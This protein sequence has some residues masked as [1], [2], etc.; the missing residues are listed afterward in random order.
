[1][2]TLAARLLTAMWEA[3]MEATLLDLYRDCTVA[4]LVDRLGSG[5]DS[6]VVLYE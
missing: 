5:G 1:M 6:G 3:G 2:S 4:K